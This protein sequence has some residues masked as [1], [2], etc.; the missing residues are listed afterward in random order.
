M[1]ISMVTINLDTVEV[2]LNFG[3]GSIWGKLQRGPSPLPTYLKSKRLVIL[4]SAGP[5]VLFNSCGQPLMSD[6]QQAQPS[7]ARS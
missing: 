6:V 2:Y 1:L 5:L 3:L 7:D 4:T